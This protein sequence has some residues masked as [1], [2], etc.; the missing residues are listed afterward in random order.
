MD[1]QEDE[2][3]CIGLWFL[4][5]GTR[6]W[7]WF[8]GE[9]EIMWLRIR[10]YLDM[11]SEL[12]LQ[13]ICCRSGDMDG[14]LSERERELYF[15]LDMESAAY[16][17]LFWSW[18]WNWNWMW[19]WMWMKWLDLQH[20]L[21]DQPGYAAESKESIGVRLREKETHTCSDFIYLFILPLGKNFCF[22]KHLLLYH[23]FEG[24]LCLTFLCLSHTHTYKSH[25]HTES[26]AE[27][28]TTITITTTTITRTIRTTAICAI[29]I[30]IIIIIRISSVL[31]VYIWRGRRK[32][33]W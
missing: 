33:W 1:I 29:I 26:D 3:S 19:M 20:I 10:E 4:F 31:Y 5:V 27:T 28:Q 15:E 23:V 2:K 30:A 7:L 21:A 25:T 17:L 18:R 24:A 6:I 8:Y 13:H 22:Y 32:D 16:L 12:Y 14:N 11:E 9:L